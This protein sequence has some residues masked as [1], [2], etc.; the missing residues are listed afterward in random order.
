[1]SHCAVRLQILYW[2]P[3]KENPR[4][5]VRN[6][7]ILKLVTLILSHSWS[8]GTEETHKHP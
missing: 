4:D 1:M 8:G 7:F 2:S 5:V 3:E 6:F